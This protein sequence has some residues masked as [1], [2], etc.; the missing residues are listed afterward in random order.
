[1]FETA[2]RR[3]QILNRRAGHVVDE[4]SL[5]TVQTLPRLV[6]RLVERLHT[7]ERRAN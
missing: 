2:P 1:M 5:C 3:F 4:Q 7:A 6:N